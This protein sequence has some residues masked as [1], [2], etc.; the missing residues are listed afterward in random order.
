MNRRLPDS[1]AIDSTSGGAQPPEAGLDQFI[2]CFEGLK[3]PRT[4]NAGLHDLHELLMIALCTVLCGGQTAAVDMAEF[5]EA[6]EEFLREFLALENG[7]PSHDTFS[8]VLRLLDPGLLCFFPAV[9]GAVR[10]RASKASSRSTARSFAR[11]FDRASG[12]SAFGMVSAWGCDQRLV[13][14]Q[15]ATDGR[16]RT[17]LPP[18]PTLLLEMLSLKGTIVTVGAPHSIASAISPGRSLIRVAIMRAGALER[19]TRG[20]STPTSPAFFSMTRPSDKAHIRQGQWRRPITAASKREASRPSRTT[21]PGCRNGH[22]WPGLESYRQSEPDR[23][24]QTELTP[25]ETAYYLLSSRLSRSSALPRGRPRPLGRGKRTAL[26]SRCRDERG[27]GAIPHGQ[28]PAE[29]RHLA[30]HGAQHHAQ[31]SLQGIPTVK[32][33]RAA[34]NNDY[35]SQLLTLS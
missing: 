20:R 13:L 34:W 12:K 10:R 14:A 6:K 7:P 4:G 21:S 9:H 2:A 11:S 30:P 25:T 5:A 28:R 3:D 18:C 32:F 16:S 33:N 24:T 19:G 8:R 15:I 35:L 27:P 17:R 29:P 22:Q 1:E 23:E 26:V 31:G